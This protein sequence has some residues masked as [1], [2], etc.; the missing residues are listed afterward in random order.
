MPQA[1]HTHKQSSAEFAPT[2]LENRRSGSPEWSAAEWVSEFESLGGFINSNGL[3]WLASEGNPQGW[4]T[5]ATEM[6]REL[7]DALRYAQ[8]MSIWQKRSAPCTGGQ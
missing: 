6:M 1:E 7:D 2:I 8:V 5:R 4:K 3:G